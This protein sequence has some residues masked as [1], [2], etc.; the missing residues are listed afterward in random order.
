MYDWSKHKIGIVLSGGG[1]KGAY[2]IGCWEA[3]AKA[4]L[5]FN[6]IAGTSIGG[7]NGYL[8]SV[9]SIEEAKSVWIQMGRSSP[10]SISI[11]RLSLFFL[12]RL[13]LLCAMILIIFVLIP[14]A[15][16]LGLTLTSALITAVEFFEF[17]NPAKALVPSLAPVMVLA[18]ANGLRKTRF[19]EFSF[20]G[21][22]YV[23]RDVRRRV[24]HIFPVEF[25]V[26]FGLVLA[27]APLVML[28][29]SIIGSGRSWRWSLLLPLC[30]A[31]NL[32]GIFLSSDA[33]FSSPGEIPLFNTERL[34]SLLVKHGTKEDRMPSHPRVY[35]ARLREEVVSIPAMVPRWV[36]KA[37]REFLPNKSWE[38][39]TAEDLDQ[40][41]EAL[42]RVGLSH[43]LLNSNQTVI[44]LEYVEVSGRPVVEAADIVLST[45][46]IADALGRVQQRLSGVE[47]EDWVVRSTSAT[48]Y[49]PGLVD[50][51]PIA[52]LLDAGDCDLIVVIFLDYAIKDANDYF[53]KHLNGLNARLRSRNPDLNDL[54]H[55]ALSKVPYLRPIGDTPSRLRR[56]KL[57]P[58]VPSQPL[59][60]GPIGFVKETLWFRESRIRQLMKLGFRDTEQ[61]LQKFVEAEASASN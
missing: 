2:E 46:A 5:T 16:L 47:D 31:L 55:E 41:R 54:A 45:S 38:E 11:F 40:Y 6:A 7:I 61:A 22:H 36:F 4:G 32:V 34:E 53:E 13:G 48:F 44:G 27:L 24:R 30:F 57:L 14:A 58:V 50:N 26:I 18:L 3:L 42:S 8:M 59:G 35:L 21:L 51:T 49:D 20:A 23:P 12:E 56:V 60:R 19:A 39:L 17:L 28:A 52:P 25:A 37:T 33:G 43:Y 15:G 9:A 29:V 1:A 10:L